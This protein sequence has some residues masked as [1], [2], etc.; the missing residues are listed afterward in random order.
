MRCSS[1]NEDFLERWYSTFHAK[2]STEVIAVARRERFLYRFG[3]TQKVATS[4]FWKWVW[5]RIHSLSDEAFHSLSDEV[6]S[7]ALLLGAGLTGMKNAAIFWV[8]HIFFV[9]F[10]SLAKYER[11]AVALSMSSNLKEYAGY[12]LNL[13]SLYLPKEDLT[14]NPKVDLWVARCK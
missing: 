14:T 1:V 9:I 4:A 3:L 2:D 8:V 11:V 12:S 6:M 7:L 5:L 10:L 13:S